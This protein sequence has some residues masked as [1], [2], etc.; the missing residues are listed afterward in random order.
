MW[1]ESGSPLLDLNPLTK[2]TATGL[3]EFAS[4]VKQELAAL[5]NLDPN[6]RYWDAII[7][8]V[9][10]R[11]LDLFTSRAYQTERDITMDPTVE[12]LLKFIDKRALALENAELACA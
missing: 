3:R 2:S 7:L 5:T 11:K 1:T 10:R 8:C 6:V 12:D 9:L 4:N